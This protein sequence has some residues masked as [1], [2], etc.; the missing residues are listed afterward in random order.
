MEKYYTTKEIAEM[1]RV[2]PRTIIKYIGEKSLKASK[3]GVGWKIAQ[4]DLRKFVES[5]AN[6]P[7]S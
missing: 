5:R 1:L 6:I 4:G 7:K 2:H 3:V